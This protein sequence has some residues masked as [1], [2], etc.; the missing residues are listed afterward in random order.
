MVGNINAAVIYCSV[1][2]PRK[3]RVKIFMAINP[4]YIYNI[5]SEGLTLKPS[6]LGSFINCFIQLGYCTKYLDNMLKLL[7]FRL[8]PFDFTLFVHFHNPQNAH[9]NAHNMSSICP[10]NA[11]KMPSKCLQNDL[12]VHLI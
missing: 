10:Q 2:N 5:G 7:L 3:S 11:L 9:K 4:R 1:F 8:C 6:N 12:C